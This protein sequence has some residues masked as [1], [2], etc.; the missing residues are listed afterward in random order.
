[1]ATEDDKKE[2]QKSVHF[3]WGVLVGCIVFLILHCMS[4][5]GM[6]VWFCNKGPESVS[7]L[8]YALV[9]ILNALTLGL[10]GLYMDIESK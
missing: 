8:R 1:M 7:S 5:R 6:A 4:A 10:W 2:N 3:G 9:N